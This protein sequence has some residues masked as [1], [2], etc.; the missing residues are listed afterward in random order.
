MSA[1][2]GN[3]SG[4]AFLLQTVLVLVHAATIS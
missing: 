4:A 3:G 1:T 2:S